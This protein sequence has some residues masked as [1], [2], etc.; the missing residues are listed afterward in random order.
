MSTIDNRLMVVVAVCALL[1][2]P[3]SAAARQPKGMQDKDLQASTACSSEC[4]KKHGTG[5]VKNEAYDPAGYESC[6]I[7]CMRQANKNNRK[8][9]QK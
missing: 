2:G 9:T 8:E 6:M 1:L 4:G 3:L 5:K 7:E